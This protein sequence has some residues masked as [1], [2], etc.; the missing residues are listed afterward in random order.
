[1]S[2][3]EEQQVDPEKQAEQTDQSD[4]LS[5]DNPSENS[6]AADD[7]SD[8]PE[9]GT[10]AWLVAAGTAAILFS[11]LGYSN[12]FGIFQAYYMQAQLSDHTPDDIAWIG[13]V[14][15]YL[16]FASGLVAGPLFDRVGAW[17]RLA[18]S[19]AFAA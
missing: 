5:Q 3:R 7:D 17:V 4:I 18:L 10:R 1:M 19:S 6:P 15:A 13:S 11:T 14:Q 12:S 9:G 16:V 2:P 8:F